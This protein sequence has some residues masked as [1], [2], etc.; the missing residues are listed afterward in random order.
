MKLHWPLGR[1][2][3]QR[4][5]GVGLRFKIDITD[6]TYVPRINW[7]WAGCIHWLCVYTWVAWEYESWHA[8]SKT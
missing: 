8:A 4:I 5:V 1:Y 6:W 2:N 3:G 7:Q